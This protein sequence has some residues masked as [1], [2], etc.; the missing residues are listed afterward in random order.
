MRKRENKKTPFANAEI[1]LF[2]LI[3]KLLTEKVLILSFSIIFGLVFYIY[4]SFQSQIFKT[5]IVIEDVPSQL[6]EHYNFLFKSNQI[7][8]QK[9]EEQY[10]NGFKSKLLSKDNLKIFLKESVEFDNFAEYL[11]LRNISIKK[12]F[13]NFNL[14]YVY[15]DKDKKVD[16]LS[17]KYYLVFTEELDGVIFL[18]N[19]VEFTKKKT[20]K[21]FKEKLKLSIKNR[22]NHYEQAFELA[23][24]LNLENPVVISKNI[25]ISNYDMQDLY[26]H[27]SKVLGEEIIYL[28]KLLIKLDNEQFNYDIF[29]EKASHSEMIS[30]PRIL[31]V[32]FGILFGILLSIV[33]II[34]KSALKYES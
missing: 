20:V 31:F 11:K 22:I 30:N 9:L 4:A 3:K 8:G 33:I 14:N 21:E 18:N 7:K 24:L 10:N 25:Q 23:K 32:F 27:G 12:F 15:E 13:T 17:N 5:Q 28:K 6:F 34:F 19:Y 26:Y 1:N 16:I 2:D 29:V